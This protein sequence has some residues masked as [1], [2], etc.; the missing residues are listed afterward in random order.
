MICST[1]SKGS[2]GVLG[3]LVMDMVVDVGRQGSAH[4]DAEGSQP[5]QETASFGKASLTSV[6]AHEVKRS[7]WHHR[8]PEEAIKI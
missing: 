3:T 4:V 2:S 5:N 6:K 1:I 7:A 8:K